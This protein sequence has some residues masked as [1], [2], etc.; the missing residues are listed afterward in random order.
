MAGTEGPGASNGG[1]TNTY[2][3]GLRINDA[4][5]NGT[6]R[7]NGQPQGAI[8]NVNHATVSV[9]AGNQYLAVNQ[10]LSF[11]WSCVDGSSGAG[12]FVGPWRGFINDAEQMVYVSDGGAGNLTGGWM[13]LA[14]GRSA[15]MLNGFS[16][17]G[18]SYQAGPSGGG[19]FTYGTVLCLAP[20]VNDRARAQ[21]RRWMMQ[22]I[23]FT[24]PLSPLVQDSL[25]DRQ[26]QS[27]LCHVDRC[28]DFRYEYGRANLA[29]GGSLHRCRGY[30]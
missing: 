12:I 9:I 13:T 26:P 20:V 24:G 1:V 7:G 25:P 22:Q 11:E 18:S 6:G 28:R 15:Q 19:T 3:P 8:L 14:A 27:G 30:R 23:G 29:A 21:I 16:S 17:S 5:G 10:A 2:G 4:L